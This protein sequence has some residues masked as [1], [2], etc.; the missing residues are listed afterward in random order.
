MRNIEFPRLQPALRGVL[1]ALRYGLAP[2][3]EADVPMKVLVA[4]ATR[5]MQVPCTPCPGA[6][7]TMPH[8]SHSDKCMPCLKLRNQLLRCVSQ[9]GLVHTAMLKGQS[10]NLK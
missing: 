6:V 1:E 3:I 4:L 9:V 2:W 8:M 10:S 7:S 5:A